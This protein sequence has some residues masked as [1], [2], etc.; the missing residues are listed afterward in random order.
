ML[1]PAQPVLITGATGFTGSRLA[2]ELAS[3]GYHVR[4]LVRPEAE[5]P[6]LAAAGV[7]LVRGKL[8]RRDDVV[9]AAAG[10]G[11]IFHIAA[12]YRTARYPDSYYHDVNVGGT[13]HVIAAAR[14]QGAACLVHCSTAGVHGHIEGAP[15]DESA[16]FNPGDVYQVTKARA[17][18]AVQEEISRGLPAVIAR[19]GAIYGPGDL[20]LLKLFRSIQRGRFVMFGPGRVNYHLVYIDDLVEAFLRCASTPEALG[21]TFILAGPRYT[22][23]NELVSLVAAAVGARRPMFRLPLLPLTFAARV[24]EGAFR[25]LGLEPPLHRRRADFF[26]KSRAFNI[27]KA[28]RLL[29]WHPQ[30]NLEEGLRRTAHWYA[31]QGMLSPIPGAGNDAQL[32]MVQEV[33]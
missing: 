8:T 6:S 24:C 19:P 12:A 20:R 11:T 17:E 5:A 15:A 30:V 33:A 16:P 14:R 28:R 10:A 9:D 13:E 18:L 25:P 27:D 29:G 23:L 7:E 26:V 3:R 21:E 22:T 2:L 31:Q 4:A 32:R 1:N